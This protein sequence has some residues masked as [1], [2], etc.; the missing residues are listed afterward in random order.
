[1]RDF[2]LFEAGATKTAF[3]KVNDQGNE[4]MILPPYNPNRNYDAFEIAINEGVEIE[5]NANI[6]FYGAGL[7]SS[8]N[9]EITEQLF[10]KHEPR[11]LKVYDDIIGGARACYSD[12]PGIVCLMGTGGLASYYN[13]KTIEKRRGGYGYLIDDLGGGFELGKRFVALWLNND[14]SKRGEDILK[15][16]LD[17]DKDTFLKTLYEVQDIDLISNLVPFVLQF[18]DE[19]KVADLITDYFD[20]FIKHQVS[21]LCEEYNCQSFSVVGSV[22]FYFYRWLVKSAKKVDLSIDQCVQNPIRRLVKYH[23]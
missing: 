23:S 10:Q 14:L 12:Q 4:E 18:E 3:I 8:A 7:G 19:P 2:Y 22:G 13:G 9:K 11:T 17:F 6:L 15:E 20:D 1:M 16:K 21:P 5:K